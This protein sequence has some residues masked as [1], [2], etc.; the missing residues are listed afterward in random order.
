MKWIKFISAFLSI[1]LLAFLPHFNFDW[2]VKIFLSCYLLYY[3]W[4]ILK[5]KRYTLEPMQ[6]M[7]KDQMFMGC[8]IK[9]EMVKRL[10]QQIENDG[11]ERSFREWYKNFESD[12]IK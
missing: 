8:D 7:T 3:F 5:R 10:K 6:E 2:I 9:E 11:N 12:Q 1:E 4:N